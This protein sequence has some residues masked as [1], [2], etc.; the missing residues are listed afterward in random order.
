MSEPALRAPG[1][2]RPSCAGKRPARASCA[3]ARLVEA[4]HRRGGLPLL[5]DAGG[6]RALT[7]DHVVPLIRGG[8]SVRGNMVPS[9]KDC[10]NRKRSLL[11]WEWEDYL[12]SAGPGGRGVGGACRTRSPRSRLRRPRRRPRLAWQPPPGS[13]I[14]SSSARSRAPGSTVKT[15]PAE[16]RLRFTERLEA[17]FSTVRVTDEAGRRVDRGEAHMEAG[18]PRQLRVPLEPHRAGPLHGALARALGGQPRRRG[19]A[20]P[21]ASRPDPRRTPCIRGWRVAPYRTSDIDPRAR[22]RSNRL[23]RVRACSTHSPRRRSDHEADVDRSG[24]SRWPSR[25]CLV[26]GATARRTSRAGATGMRPGAAK[27]EGKVN[28]NEA[29]RAQLM[30]LSGVGPGTADRIISLPPG[31]WAVPA[32]AGSR[33]G[34][35]RGQG[36]DRAERGAD[37]GEVK[38]A[39]ARSPANG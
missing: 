27:A 28:I 19:R 7:A 38:K 21:S 10:N 35:G 18:A 22:A 15:A 5:P 34:R 9:C 39:F 20:S 25:W 30:K 33:E 17:A 3:P 16:V 23:R 31:P 32:R 6:A 29:T 26:A 24:W 12:Q 2:T 1:R 37:R 36:R 13:P 14:P 4:P 11:P 8:R